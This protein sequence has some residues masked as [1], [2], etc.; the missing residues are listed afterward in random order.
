M[1][2]ASAA[3]AADRDWEEFLA[4][5]AHEIKNPLASIKGYADLLLRRAAKDPA[6][7]YRKGLATISQQVG[8]T[9]SLLDQLSD[10]T[11]LGTGPLPIDRHEADFALIVDQVVQEYQAADQQHTIAFDGDATALS[12]VSTRVAWP[13]WLAR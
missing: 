2:R 11:R 5:A 8:R 7:P 12:A 13:R 3:G 4:H 9:T 1:A 6:D 10:I